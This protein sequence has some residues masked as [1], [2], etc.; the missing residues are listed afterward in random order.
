[1]AR[2]I[3]DQFA[4]DGFIVVRGLLDANQVA[5]YIDR[6]RAL[7]GAADRWTEPDGVNRHPEFWPLI[8]GERLLTAVSQILGPDVRY[9][10]HTDLHVG[11]SSFSW[12]RDCVTRRFGDGA[13]W[14][15]H[16]CPYR[17]ARV[18]IYLQSSEESGFRL[19]FVKGSHRTG[20][21]DPAEQRRI[22]RRTNAAAN[23]VSGLSGLDLLGGHAEWVAPDP[24]DCVIFDP[25]ILHTG[26]RF[27]GQKYSIFLAYGI[28]NTHFYNHWHYYLRLRTD[29]AY[30]KV[31][32]ALAERL[33]AA[34]LLAN[35]PPDDLDIDRAWIP[36]ATF[37]SVAKRFK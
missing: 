18:G 22:E 21:L 28:E 36:S 3:R 12:H 30:S 20:G 27:H 31:P 19:G 26:S 24:G 25:R 9:L 10:P 11:F 6:L 7:A 37:V 16:E 13:D 35:E 29:L 32:A 1:M 15:E 5:F 4:E 34:G 33:L 2:P 14:N 23:V 8:C 17:I